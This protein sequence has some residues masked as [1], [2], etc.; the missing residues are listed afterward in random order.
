[1]GKDK[2]A[3]TGRVRPSEW[4][5][6]YLNLAVFYTTDYNLSQIDLAVG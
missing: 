3:V 6:E 1:M 2:A 4:Q 5:D